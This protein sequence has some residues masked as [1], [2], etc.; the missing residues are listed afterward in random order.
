MAKHKSLKSLAVAYKKR[1]K[2]FETKVFREVRKTGLVIQN[3]AIFATPVDT[4]YARSR[5]II[6][7]GEPIADPET[8]VVKNIKIGQEI[9]AAISAS[10]G[11]DEI[12]KWDGNGSIFINNPVEYV[13]YLDNG[14]E[15]MP[16][17]N[18]SDNAIK[19][20][21]DYWNSIKI[22]GDE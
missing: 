15:Y 13:V 12:K 20:G 14:T 4:G 16:P 6:S 9:S 3:A 8:G 10:Q 7:I 2:E 19:A 11:I 1:A 17:L 21:I 5:W 18:I 22:F